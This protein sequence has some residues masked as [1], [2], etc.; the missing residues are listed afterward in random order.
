MCDRLRGCEKYR[1]YIEPWDKFNMYR[2]IP[3]VEYLD[4]ME[5]EKR[6][7]LIELAVQLVRKCKHE[8]R[9]KAL[10]LK[11]RSQNV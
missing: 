11:Q 7:R 6:Q 4:N 5:S 10:K 8:N 9:K 3:T 2:P 1:K